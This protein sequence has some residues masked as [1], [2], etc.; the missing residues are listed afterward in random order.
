MRRHLERAQLEQ[1]EAAGRGFG[2]VELVDAELG[3]VR[4]AG[5]VDEQVPQHAI[6]QPRLGF[7]SGTWELRERQLQLVQLRIAALVNA[8]VLRGGADEQPANRNDSDGWFCQ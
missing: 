7:L 1:A 8:R 2:R 6:D 5:Q 3:A 4:V